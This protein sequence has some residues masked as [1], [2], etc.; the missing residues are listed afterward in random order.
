[1]ESPT[2]PVAAACKWTKPRVEGSVGSVGHGTREGFLLR[3]QSETL[4][5]NPRDPPSDPSRG[6]FPPQL[7]Q[8]CKVIMSVLAPIPGI[9]V[10]EQLHKE[11]LTTLMLRA[12]I[13]TM[14][15]VHDPTF[16]LTASAPESC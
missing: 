6:T 1:M 14:L 7:L 9:P 10:I 13:Q 3:S 8:R 2:N 4:S 11:P 15:S 5:K 16:H 12:E